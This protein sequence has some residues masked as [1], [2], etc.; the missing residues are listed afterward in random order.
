VNFILKNGEL[1]H[2]KFTGQFQNEK[3]VNV[4]NVLQE[5]LGITYEVKS[6]EIIITGKGC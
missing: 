6:K 4:L 5:A 1:D 3:L 2:C